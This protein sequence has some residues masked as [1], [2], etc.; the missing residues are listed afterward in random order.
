[1]T[2]VTLH[3]GREVSS[4][5][6]EWKAECLRKWE[7]HHPD[8][9]H[10]AHLMNLRGI[11]GAADR[12]AYIEAVS[13]AEGSYAAERLKEAYAKVWEERQKGKA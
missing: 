13:R 9:T 5:S 10:H 6:E 12:R 7:A 8:S 1:M 3:D 4:D 11:P 2:T